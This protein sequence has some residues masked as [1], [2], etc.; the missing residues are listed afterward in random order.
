MAVICYF[1]ISAPARYVIQMTVMYKFVFFK[2]V[3]VKQSYSAVEVTAKG[4]GQATYQKVVC[5]A[6]KT[7]LTKIHLEA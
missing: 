6:R 4:W 7:G 3:Y 1:F 2:L 5:M